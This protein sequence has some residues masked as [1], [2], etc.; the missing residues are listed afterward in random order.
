MDIYLVRHAEAAA[1]WGKSSDPGLSEL[2]TEQAQVA[3]RQL[4]PQL[5]ADTT[6]VSSPLARAQQTAVPLAMAMGSE[7]VVNHAFSEIPAPVPLAERQDWLRQFM[8]QRWHEQPPNLHQWRESAFTQLLA[9]G[10]PSVVFTHFLVINAVIGRI[11]GRAET[12]CFWPDNASVT[13]LRR[14]DDALELIALGRQ[15]DTVI[16]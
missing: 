15:M 1:S 6:L 8:Q 5:D 11:L 16:N 14:K 2:G 12:L 10:K 3:A 4:L 13:H 7:V 9:L